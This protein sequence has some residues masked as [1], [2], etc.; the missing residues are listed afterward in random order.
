MAIEAEYK[1]FSSNKV[2]TTYRRSMAFL[3]AEVKKSTD[4]WELHSVLSGFNP[5]TPPCDDSSLQSSLPNNKLSK[6]ENTLP[7]FQTALELSRQSAK[8]TNDQQENWSETDSKHNQKEIT[9]YFGAISNSENPK[10]GSP[11][12]ITN[13]KNDMK[14]STGGNDA[15]QSSLGTM[16]SKSTIAD[17]PSDCNMKEPTKRKQSDLKRKSISEDKNV[18]PKTSEGRERKEN[19]S[20]RSKS[21]RPDN[22]KCSSPSNIHKDPVKHSSEESHRHRSDLKISGSAEKDIDLEKALKRIK[23]LEESNKKL[24]SRRIKELEE[25]NKKL[26]HSGKKERSSKDRERSPNKQSS[27]LALDKPV[28]DKKYVDKETIIHKSPSKSDSDRTRKQSTTSSSSAT[29]LKSPPLSSK[30]SRVQSK[31]KLLGLSDSNSSN[32]EGSDEEDQKV[33]FE[34]LFGCAN[35]SSG[36]NIP[37]NKTKPKTTYEHPSNVKKLPVSKRITTIKS[38]KPHNISDSERD[39]SSSPNL[40]DLGEKTK[41]EKEVMQIAEQEDY[42]ELQEAQ[43][44]MSMQEPDEHDQLAAWLGNLPLI[45]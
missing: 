17:S 8:N 44:V 18:E 26:R 19:G 28:C 7:G 36:S 3:M 31:L 25:E 32:N 38:N 30:S 6:S 10:I 13:E 37:K 21:D 9:S 23:E 34:N 33:A 14:T 29:S 27:K 15:P 45:F 24:A 35:V 11:G 20:S 4:A 16:E 2:V 12:E 41:I 5:N 22:K 1:I 43:K 42:V 39:S 40:S